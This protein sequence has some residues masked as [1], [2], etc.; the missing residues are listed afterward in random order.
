MEVPVA[1]GRYIKIGQEWKAIPSGAMRCKYH[2]SEIV[3]SS[4]GQ[5]A[6]STIKNIPLL[7]N[8]GGY[9]LPANYRERVNIMEEA[10]MIEREI[11]ERGYSR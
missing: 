2:L 7:Q 1:I 11:E 4:K 10:L 6:V 5:F 9:S 3:M 8:L